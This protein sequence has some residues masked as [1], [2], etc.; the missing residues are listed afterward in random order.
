MNL[1]EFTESKRTELEIKLQVAQAQVR[2]AMKEAQMVENQLFEAD[3]QAGSA[4]NAIK[5]SGF[6][7]ILLQKNHSAVIITESNGT[8]HF[9][10]NSFLC[11]LIF[12]LHHS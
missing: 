1:Y 3:L 12:Y 4:R 10:Y 5:N 9:L 11:Y 7:D 8:P 2:K 6:G